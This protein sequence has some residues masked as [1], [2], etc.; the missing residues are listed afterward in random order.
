MYYF[1]EA[2]KFAAHSLHICHRFW[3]DLFTAWFFTFRTPFGPT[4]TKINPNTNQ[5]HKDEEKPTIVY[6]IQHF[7]S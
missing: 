4:A 7:Q 2:T 6:E 1:V 5:S 3:S